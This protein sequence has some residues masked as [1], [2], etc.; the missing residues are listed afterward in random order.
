MGALGGL[1]AAEAGQEFYRRFKAGETPDIPG[2]MISGM[3]VVGG[4][5][6]MAPHPIVRGLG[7]AASGVSPLGLYLL[8]KMRGKIP[9]E[10]AMRGPMPEMP[11]VP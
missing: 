5:A 1:G 2:M 3:G 10:M 7:V 6:S 4:L 8:D 9:P 11:V